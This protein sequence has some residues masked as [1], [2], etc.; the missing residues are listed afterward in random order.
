MLCLRAYAQDSDLMD[1][2][3]NCA[4]DSNELSRLLCYDNVT[5]TI[6]ESR[7]NAVV[8]ADRSD[9]WVAQQQT[10]PIDD[11]RTV[12]LVNIAAEGKSSLGRPIGLAIRCM[13]GTTTVYINWNDYLGSEA[14]VLT[15]I[16][17]SEAV[18]QRWSLSTD[19]EA[20]FYPRDAVA[21]VKELMT[22]DRL[23]AQV[24]PYN[25]NPVT[26]IWNIAGLSTAIEPLRKTCNW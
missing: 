4:K 24:T 16:G 6:G 1:R 5:K 15:R 26:A 8:D 22:A 9:H 12:A 25:E 20:T 7:P 13:S 21:F 23:V 19:N 11:S 10:N 18:R 17:S 2:L 14:T 3:L